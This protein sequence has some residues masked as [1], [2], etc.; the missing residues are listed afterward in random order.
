MTH[1]GKCLTARSIKP[2]VT[3]QHKF[4]NT[5]LYGSYSP[6]TG[7]SLVYEI[8]GISKN[9]FHQYLVKLSEY[10][11]NEYKIVVID[12]AGFHSTKDIQLPENIYLLPLPPYS[13]E[14]NPCEKIW[15]YIKDRY[16]NKTFDNMK[17]LKEWLYKQVNSMTPE[18]IM[19]ITHHR[20]YMGAFNSAFNT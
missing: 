7:D 6:I 18:R 11:A 2:I 3:Y 15:Q 16:K 20:A 10:K 14:L 17:S 1:I 19:S 9:I 13:P 8:E 5:Y 12:N 4:T